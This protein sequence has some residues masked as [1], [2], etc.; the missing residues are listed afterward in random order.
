MSTTET[1]AVPAGTWAPDPV[2]STLGFAVRYLAGTFTGSFSQSMF[3]PKDLIAE[4]PLGDA[5][6]GD[7]VMTSRPRRRSHVPFKTGVKR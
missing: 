3:T 6:L 7:A 4:L 1:K 2:H 5:G